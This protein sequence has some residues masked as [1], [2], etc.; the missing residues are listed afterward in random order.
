MRLRI[1][2]KEIPSK[3]FSGPAEERGYLETF[4]RTEPGAA[5]YPLS[6]GMRCAFL[7][8]LDRTCRPWLREELEFQ[9]AQSRP[10][11]P[12]PTSDVIAWLR[13]HGYS[14]VTVDPSGRRANSELARRRTADLALDPSLTSVVR[15]TGPDGDF[16][17][18]RLSARP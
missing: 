14:Y 16:A 17:L 9:E 12:M 3:G 13:A 8:G 11:D 7:A 2:T 6:G 10:K 18:F 15:V 1:L 5:V 4:R